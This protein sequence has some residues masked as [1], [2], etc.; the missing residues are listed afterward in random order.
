MDNA[1]KNVFINPYDYV[2]YHH[3][4]GLDFIFEKEEEKGEVLSDEEVV[5]CIV[6]YSM[7]NLKEYGVLE[8]DEL[9]EHLLN[10]DPNHVITHSTTEQFYF[11]EI[12]NAFNEYS[13]T[14]NFD[15]LHSKLT[16][17]EIAASSDDR[18]E[19]EEKMV[20]LATCS[21]A[22]HSLVFWFEKLEM[23][24]DNDG[25]KRDGPI[26]RFFKNVAKIVRA[27]A[28]GV[29][30]GWNCDHELHHSMC[31]TAIKFSKGAAR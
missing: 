30:H 26:T 13:D 10:H 21:V 12:D 8:E 22:H 4:L 19:T 23:K 1:K 6:T 14:I 27:D 20:I 25:K 7:L 2:G 9:R 17:I 11:T 16:N 5:E 31:G 18:L 28:H 15:G 24:D 29:D 3:N